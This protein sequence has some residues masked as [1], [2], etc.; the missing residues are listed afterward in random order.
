MHKDLPK[1]SIMIVTLNNASTLREC[2][3][4][5]TEQDY[6]KE[7]IEYINIDGGSTDETKAIMKEFGFKVVDSPIKRNAEAQRAVGLK[8]IKNPIWV[9]LDADNFLPHTKWLRQMVEPFM[10]EEKVFYVQTLHYTH[11]KS[12]SLFNRYCSLFGV[13]DS[14]VYYIGR[15]DRVSWIESRWKLGDKVVEKGNYF[16]VK[17][18]EKN[19]PT[20]G[21][22]GVMVKKDMLLNYAQSSPDKFLHTDVYVDLIRK[23]YNDGFAVVKNDV[24]H[25]TA[26]SLGN[27][28]K[29][30][31][32]FLTYFFGQ[33]TPRRYKIYD[34]AK[35]SDNLKMLKFAVYTVTMVKPLFDSAIGYLKVRD[36][37][38]FLH[39]VACWAFL[40]AY[41]FA[42]I[43][44]VVRKLGA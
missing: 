1:L 8:I 12:A 27:L 9:V 44:K 23:G 29:K 24:I 40:W 42:T 32:A 3:G 2:L 21:C 19:L 14:M 10:K 18:S 28:I 11:Q 26:Y 13:N 16:L 39:P 37:A 22:N 17:Y 15:P 38:W 6:P 4:S 30:R 36:K 34:P 5:I 35:M 31:I 41:G 25:A 7:L 33:E 43:K 20:L